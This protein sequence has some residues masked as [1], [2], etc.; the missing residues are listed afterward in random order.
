[1]LLASYVHSYTCMAIIFVDENNDAKVSVT[2]NDAKV[3]DTNND[4]E[5]TVISTEATDNGVYYLYST[6]MCCKYVT[7]VQLA[8][9]KMYILHVSQ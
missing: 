7:S 6:Y 9:I 1:M 8:N 5:V 2:N 3:T 4:A